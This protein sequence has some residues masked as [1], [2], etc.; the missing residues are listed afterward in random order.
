MKIFLSPSV[1]DATKCTKFVFGRPGARTS[2]GELTCSYSVPQTPGGE[3]ACCAHS[4]SR[5]SASLFS[6]S[7]LE[8]SHFLIGSDAWSQLT[9]EGGTEFQVVGA[10]QL[11]DRMPKSVRAGLTHK[12][13]NRMLRAPS[14]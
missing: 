6:P 5:P 1:F 7:G 3:G 9:T 10:M 14:Y 12:R 8:P 4:R 13:T 11:R 2:L